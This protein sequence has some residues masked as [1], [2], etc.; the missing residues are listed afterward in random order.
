MDSSPLPLSS[1]EPETPATA[2]DVKAAAS[3]PL[4]K[5]LVGPDGI[6]ALPRWLIYLAMAWIVFEIETW[7]LV[8]L[9]PHLNAIWSQ[10]MIE[11]SRMVAVILPA[12]VMV[13]I[14]RRPFGDF[15]LPARRAFG[16]NFWVG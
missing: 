3:S 15:G 9:E 11:A 16:R 5:A 8:S 2:D 14:E 12:F 6:Y 1:A 7:L 10:M 4:R 13:R